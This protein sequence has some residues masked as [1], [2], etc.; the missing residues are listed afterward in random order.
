VNIKEG[1]QKRV[2]IILFKEWNVWKRE[3]F[4]PSYP[5]SPIN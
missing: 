1:V 3:R 4:E 2:L 5:I